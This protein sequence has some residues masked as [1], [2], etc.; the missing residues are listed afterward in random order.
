[1][2][3]SGLSLCGFS[4]RVSLQEKVTNVKDTETKQK[5]LERR[6]QGKSLRTIADELGVGRQT[7]VNW[8]RECKEEIE[9]LKAIELD[10]LHEQYRLTT[11]AKVERYGAELKRVTEELEKRDLSN[12]PT[13]KLYDIMIKL[14]ARIEETCPVLVLRD[15]NE[16][17]D[18]RGL[19]DLAALRSAR[20][21]S[22]RSAQAGRSGNGGATVVADDLVTVQLTI[23][24]RF[25]AGEIN[26]RTAMTEVALVNSLL[27]GIELSSV[28]EELQHVK[29]LLRASS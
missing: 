27:K 4:L 3:F 28:Q 11:H 25:K 14:H 15:E 8:A 21:A 23:L 18:Q 10:A 20:K 6:A 24:Q 19:R 17:A 16:L 5:F 9:N 7:L 12:V 13:P 29:E 2:V 26:E 22:A 1:L